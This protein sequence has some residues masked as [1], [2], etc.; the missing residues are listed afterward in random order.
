MPLNLA[1]AKLGLLILAALTSAASGAAECL[2]YGPTVVAIEG[3]VVRLTF[4]GRPN[5]ESVTG[6]DEPETGFY[7][8]PVR[9]FCLR[10]DAA[11]PGNEAK[12]DVRLVQLLLDQAGY[13]RLRPLLGQ[14]VEVQ[15]QL[16]GAT[17]GHHHAPVMMSSVQVRSAS[18]R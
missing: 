12:S 1:A 15:G 17:T 2:R 8:V 13:D 11:E 6:G 14:T 18:L 16:D 3:Q 4:P 10:G 9:P 7:L 5:Y